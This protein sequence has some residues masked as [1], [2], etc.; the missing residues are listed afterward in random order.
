MSSATNE[1]DLRTGR[2]LWADSSALGVEA[3][4]LTASTSVDIAVIG[5]GI[6]GAFM[7]HA[8]SSAAIGL[9]ETFGRPAR[10]LVLDRRPP[11][12]G[13]TLASTA[14][15]QWEIDLPLVEL[16]KKIGSEKASRAYTRCFRALCDLTALIKS[17]RIRCAYEDR[18]TLYLA[19]DLYGSRALA[20]ETDA[21]RELGLP[22]Q[23]LSAADLRDN[24]G[25][26]RT[27]AILSTGSSCANPGQLAAALLR[28]ATSKGAAIHSPAEVLDVL[29]DPE[30]VS[31]RLDNGVVVRAKK[32]VFCT[33][34]ELPKRVCIPKA[35]ILSTWAI[36]SDTTAT[37]PDWLKTT[38]VWEASDPYLYFRSTPDG[39][40]I[41]G[42]EDEESETRHS[43][44]RLLDTKAKTLK[45]KLE[46]LVPDIRLQPQYKWA[47]AFGSS[48][49]GLPY[50]AP[51]EDM[52]NVWVVAGLG[53]NGITYSVIASQIITSAFAG[54]HDTDC[55]LYR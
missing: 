51:A 30:G 10:I 14:M 39:R 55:D 13:S 35:D 4:P 15:L 9:K 48:T 2:S 1:R 38:M 37:I 20:T 7:A 22:S 53:G 5:A 33:G 26:N 36:A 27:G 46:Q 6:T 32:V 42:G 29:S 12:Y 3:K 40:I 43:I 31:L 54:K 45:T 44:A 49:T 19:G 23:F 25:I 21:R 16:T 50:I 47:G 41:L 28:R 8:L 24:Y 17:E 34:Y 11:L 18:S 52:D